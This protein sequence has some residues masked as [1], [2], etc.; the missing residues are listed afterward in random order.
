MSIRLLIVTR[1]FWPLSDESSQRLLAWA[2]M[3]RGQG[4]QPTVLTA[5]WHHQWPAESDCAEMR[6]VRLLPAPRTAWTETLF[7]RHLATWSQQ[8]RD[9]FDGMYCD[10][11]WAALGQL[12]ARRSAESPRLIGAF[13]GISGV[14]QGSSE[15][16][17]LVRTAAAAQRHAD[18][19]VVPH[20]YADRQL[21]SAGFPPEQLVRIPPLAWSVVDRSPT[22][23]QRAQRALQLAN[24]DMGPDPNRRL[25]VYLGSQDDNPELE[26]IL[27]AAIR[28]VERDEPLRLWLIGHGSKTRHWHDLVKHAACHRDIQFFPAF[29]DV[30]E[31][32]TIADG[33]VADSGEYYVPWAIA[34]GLP[35]LASQLSLARHVVPQ[36]LSDAWCQGATIDGW[37]TM[38]ESW[39]RERGEWQQRA[40]QA[41]QAAI[42]APPWELAQR[43]WRE[44]FAS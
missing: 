35:V 37:V 19:C 42:A 30:E 10:E 23:R 28:L 43:Q 38:M 17:A 40:M 2:R 6:V 1:R 13:H 5:R 41:R 34:S 33:L 32:L 14:G 11:S 27:Q 4:I 22:A 24:Q 31:L 21:R 9:A 12:A 8:H 29:D 25:L 16:A 3:L 15:V 20:A 36:E 7:L 18:R 44:V 39:L 26:S